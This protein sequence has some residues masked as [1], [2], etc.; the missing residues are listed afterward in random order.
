[1]RPLV[2]R[3]AGY[4]ARGRRET[5]A[6]HVSHA[7]RSA[8]WISRMPETTKP[9]VQGGGSVIAAEQTYVHTGT[10]LRLPRSRDL[11]GIDD[12]FLGIPLDTA[13]TFRPGARFG[14]GGIRSGSVQ[15]AE[16]KNFPHG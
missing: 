16:L 10:F 12:V 8:K 2:W 15:L 13:T 6:D 1:M 4:P 14:P 7:G 3:R 9:V 5:E 11:A